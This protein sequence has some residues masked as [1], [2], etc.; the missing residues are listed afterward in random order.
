MKNIK[1]L[2]LVALLNSITIERLILI[3]KNANLIDKLPLGLVGTVVEVYNDDKQSK[4]LVEFA[5]NKGQEYA[6]AILT[7]EELIVLQYELAFS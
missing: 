5:N 6:M 3:E 4:Y 2:D 7:A 1:L